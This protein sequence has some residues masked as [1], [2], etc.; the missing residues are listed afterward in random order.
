MDKFQKHNTFTTNDEGSDYVI[1]SISP[2]FYHLLM[3]QT[4]IILFSS[5][6]RYSFTNHF[7]KYSC[8]GNFKWN[9]KNYIWSQ[10]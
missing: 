7:H 5:S 8:F 6:D 9:L 2:S 3:S 4:L 1:F 10:G